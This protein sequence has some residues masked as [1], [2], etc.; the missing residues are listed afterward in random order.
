MGKDLTKISHCILFC[1]G[2]SC[3]KKGAEK[4]ASEIRAHLKS[5]GFY[6]SV[7]TVKTM[8]NGR[9]EDAP[10]LI[11]A[12]EFVWYKNMTVEKGIELVENHIRRN[13]PLQ[14]Q[15]LFVPGM[16]RMESDNPRS[17]YK[18]KFYERKTDMEFGEVLMAKTD[19]WEQNLYPMLK[20]IFIKFRKNVL[21]KVP[22][23]SSQFISLD[24]D[25]ELS[26]DEKWVKIQHDTVRFEFAI[27][28]PSKEDQLF[29]KENRLGT[30]EVYKTL[31]NLDH[32][33]RFKSKMNETKLVVKCKS[34]DLSF[35]EHLNEIYLINS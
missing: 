7:H 6:D 35:W 20:D 24:D 25:L 29:F 28:V 13:K 17:L 2:G 5:E 8:C 26:Y 32:G 12:P 9:C 16:D 21:V 15:V 14:D 30:V 1:T 34:D 4:I 3:R 31:D 27:G 22:S 23:F 33:V 19:P 18:P 10:T 11:V